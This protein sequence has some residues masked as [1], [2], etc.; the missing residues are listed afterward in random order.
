MHPQAKFVPISPDLDI[1]A[2]VQDTPNFEWATHISASDI[3]VLGQQQFEKLVSVHVINGG[4]PL[5]IK[6]WNEQLPRKLFSAK[7]LEEKYNR[8]REKVWDIRDRKEIS[9]TLGHYLRSMKQLTDQWTLQNYRDERRQRLYLK[10]IDCPPKWQE[11]LARVL[12][13]LIFYLNEDIEGGQSNSNGRG[14]RQSFNDDEDQDM[15]VDDWPTARAGDLMSSLP[16]KM[17][18]ENLMCYIGHEGTYT[19]AHRE[20]CASLGQN[21]MVEASGSDDG[22]K[23]GSSIWFM[24]ET[25]DREVVSEYF[26]SMLGHDVEVESHFAQINAWKKAAFPVYIVE[27]KV[28]DL[29]LIP[30]LAPHQVWNRGTRTMK[31]AW[32]RTVVET[33]ELALHEALPKARLVCRDEQYK[34][35]AIIYYTLQKYHKELEYAQSCNDVVSPSIINRSRRKSMRTA[36]VADDFEKLFRLY[37]EIVADEILNYPEKLIEFLPFDSN[38]TC[39]YCR[40]NI[41]NR[42]LTCKHCVRPLADGDED[43]YDVCMECYAMG[44]SC[45]CLSGLMWCEQWPW[46]ELVSNYNKWRATLISNDLFADGLPPPPPLE[47]VRLRAGKKSVAQICQEQLQRRPFCDKAKSAVEKWLVKPEDVEVDDDGSVIKKKYTN[48]AANRSDSYRCHVCCRKDYCFRLAFCTSPGCSEAYCYG[49]LYRGFD[50]MPQ[51]VMQQDHWKCPRC[52]EICNCGACRRAGVTKPYIPKGTLLGLDTSTVADDRSVELL[53]NFR[54]HNLRWLKNGGEE[55]RNIGSKRMRR[56]RNEADAAKARSNGYTALDCFGS[57]QDGSQENSFLVGSLA[58]RSAGTIGNVNDAND[59]ERS[60]AAGKRHGQ[61]RG[62][63][64]SDDYPDPLAHTPVP[65]RTFGRAFYM[66]DDDSPGKILFDSY[67][68]PALNSLVGSPDSLETSPGHMESYPHKQASRSRHEK[69]DFSENDA[70]KQKWNGLASQPTANASDFHSNLDP[71]LLCAQNQLVGASVAGSTPALASEA[72]SVTDAFAGSLVTDAPGTLKQVTASVNTATWA[73]GNGINAKGGKSNSH[74]LYAKPLQLQHARREVSHVVSLISDDEADEDRPAVMRA[75]VRNVLA[76]V[77]QAMSAIN[78]GAAKTTT[79]A[80]AAA[81]KIQIGTAD[82]ATDSDAGDKAD[83]LKLGKYK[84]GPLR[85]R[86]RAPQSASGSPTSTAHPSA[87]LAKRLRSLAPAAELFSSQDRDSVSQ[88]HSTER[89]VKHTPSAGNSGS[90]DGHNDNG[91]GDSEM[92]VVQK[93]KATRPTKRSAGRTSV[94]VAAEKEETPSGMPSQFSVPSAMFMSLT[95]RKAAKVGRFSMSG[96][97]G[98]SALAVADR[99]ESKETLP[100]VNLP[101]TPAA[102][103]LPLMTGSSPLELAVRSPRITNKSTP[104]AMMSTRYASGSSGES[105]GER[106]VAGRK[107]LRSASSARGRG[108]RAQGHSHPVS[109]ADMFPNK[110]SGQSSRELAER[111]G[112]VGGDE[113]GNTTSQRRAS[114]GVDSS[115]SSSGLP[116]RRRAY[117]GR[118]GRGV[119][120]RGLGRAQPAGQTRQNLDAV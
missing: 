8:K 96:S 24:T 53:I 95:E 45:A 94:A 55:G 5:V 6:D 52:L 11:T 40:S 27:Q 114:S 69:R 18:A 90:T 92:F 68:E 21:I 77:E 37:T 109:S 113:S 85:K 72:G 98:R 42:F 29:I 102:L 60:I 118:R 74:K 104:D 62:G 119:I 19:P 2:L 15:F 103:E 22:E 46:T 116:V 49:V 87:P 80:A 71:A 112:E 106:G 39:S 88:P 47:A 34:N 101:A 63:E 65:E 84:T 17:R 89:T 54:L 3:F 100:L 13:R 108:T 70:A 76:S 12:P 59:L 105:S 58:D 115:A 43:T 66:H 4:K 51:T 35:K 33:L 7:W 120:G 50:L 36:Q 20:M 30:P 91:R 61:A 83:A 117:Y 82:A 79:S 81:N 64:A 48:S 28:G 86:G 23:P 67:H 57:M 93:R 97:K 26:L 10:D 14:D 44:R 110:A 32:N 78:P 107:V 75:V 16:P 25:K 56:L 41:F 31:V 38:I 111:D 73:G 99:G 9:M 1:Q